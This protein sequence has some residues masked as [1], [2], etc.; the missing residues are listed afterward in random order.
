M[1]LYNVCWHAIGYLINYLINDRCHHFVFGY[2]PQLSNGSLNLRTSNA[3]RSGP[4][5]RP[6]LMSASVTNFLIHLYWS[7]AEPMPTGFLGVGCWD[8]MVGLLMLENT[9]G[10]CTYVTGY[11]HVPVSFSYLPCSTLRILAK[12]NINKDDDELREEL[13]QRLIDCRLMGPYAQISLSMDP[14]R[15]VLRELPHGCWSNVFVM[16]QAHCRAHNESPASKST[17]F[18]VANGWRCALRFHKKT[19]HQVCLTCSALKMHIRNSKETFLP[20]S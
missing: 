9:Y 4:S 15:L 8:S 2:P 7:A 16:Y 14:Q 10:G 1:S 6:S 5:S 17:F 19:Q 18:A 12:S 20:F 13:L 3:P 11:L